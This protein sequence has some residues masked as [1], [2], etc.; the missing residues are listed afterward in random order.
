MSSALT[1]AGLR[2]GY[3]A[4]EVIREIDLDVSEGEV[5]AILGRNGVGKTTLVKTIT[6]VLPATAGTVSVLGKDVTRRSAHHIARRGVAYVAQEGGLFDELSVEEN[7]RL[8]LPRRTDLVE[9]GRMA[10]DAFPIFRERMS[11]KAGTLSGGQRKLLMIARTM[12]QRPKLIVLDE[13]S[14]GVQPSMV[15][16]I[17][18]AMRR[19]RERGAAI[20]IVE[21]KL[22]FALGLASRYVVLKSGLIVA[23]GTVGPT[24]TDDVA[25]H[26]GL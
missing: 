24:T 4:V 12:L 23:R 5:V 13:V 6:A 11:Q 16:Q 9:A 14:E 8:V 3:G 17:D 20:L 15:S 10:F 1:V 18:N 2:S 7:L 26:L 19:Q 25:R 22:D 21:Q